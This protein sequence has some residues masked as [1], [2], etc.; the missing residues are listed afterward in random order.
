MIMSASR[1]LLIASKGQ[2]EGHDDY[3]SEEERY[4]WD[5]RR[6]LEKVEAS[7]SALRTLSEITRPYTTGLRR[8]EKEEKYLRDEELA[9]KSFVS[10]FI[11][12]KENKPNSSAS[13]TQPR[14]ESCDGT[15][16]P[17]TDASRRKSIWS[18]VKHVKTTD[19]QAVLD[20]EKTANWKPLRKSKARQSL[21]QFNV[22]NS[23]NSS[24]VCDDDVSSQCKPLPDL[25]APS[26][27]AED[28]RTP[29]RAVV[30]LNQAPERRSSRSFSFTSET[31]STV[32]PLESDSEA[33]NDSSIVTSDFQDQE[34]PSLTRA[35]SMDSEPVHH[36]PSRSSSM[37]SMGEQTP[38][39]Q[40]RSFLKN[41]K[42]PVRCSPI[43]R[44]AFGEEFAKIRG[45]ISSPDK[46]VNLEECTSPKDPS[47][48][49]KGLVAYVEVRRGEDD[50]TGGFRWKLKQ[51]GATV[52]D[53]LNKK[54]T[55]CVF[56][57]GLLST[58][59]K[60]K[61]MGI[62]IV[63]PHWVMACDET[64]MR[65]QESRYPIEKEEQYL[66]AD[67]LQKCIKRPKIMSPDLGSGRDEKIISRRLQRRSVKINSPL[68]QSAPLPSSIIKTPSPK[69]ISK[70]PSPKKRL[71][72]DP[73]DDYDG[74]L[75]MVEAQVREKA[76]SRR[77]AGGLNDTPV[78]FETRLQQLLG[79]NDDDAQNSVK[80]SSPPLASI[81]QKGK[82]SNTLT[83]KISPKK[84][85]KV[86]PTSESGTTS[87]VMMNWLQRRSPEAGQS[88]QK[89]D[90]SSHSAALAAS[91]AADEILNTML[92]SGS[93]DKHQVNQPQLDSVVP[94]KS[95]T[96]DRKGPF[97][98][99]AKSEIGKDLSKKSTKNLKTVVKGN[100]AG[101]DS[102]RNW[103]SGMKSR[104]ADKLQ[105]NVTT[106]VK[107]SKSPKKDQNQMS[108][109][110]KKRKVISSDKKEILLD[111]TEVNLE[112]TNPLKKHCGEV[113]P[114]KNDSI[115]YQDR[116]SK[117]TSTHCSDNANSLCSP[118]R[119]SGSAVKKDKTR[120]V[121]LTPRR[122]SLRLTPVKD[123]S[124]AGSITILET[125]KENKESSFK[126]AGTFT[127]RKQHS[128]KSTPSKQSFNRSL[129]VTP[130]KLEK[131]TPKKSVTPSKFAKS[132]KPGSKQDF[133]FKS[134]VFSAVF[135]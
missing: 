53:T 35:N 61:Q 107:S 66:L 132:V 58:Y 24:T 103:L 67:P 133:T 8:A 95:E 20:M 18:P 105:E 119:G 32:C 6:M 62:H 122:R 60:A 128:C 2:K 104:V 70:V 113:T 16:K 73:E 54:V 90:L 42:S 135:G 29:L 106:S 85:K 129:T 10:N 79:R 45:S 44:Q 57:E 127:P 71:T 34:L 114:K 125:V 43:L 77:K 101:S 12:S 50:R 76:K 11:K 126:N 111:D 80:K 123:T 108:T 131:S 26:K 86:K 130:S 112:P 99:T 75:A 19:V 21:A 47:K 14:G 88:C 25:D 100:A 31:V 89:R 56:Q 27:A 92:T 1:T 38:I 3:D 110:N 30:G 40:T 124:L 7:A 28:L 69:K 87:S 78:D 41:I 13:E 93:K 98:F 55:H 64:F 81:F 23:H 52:S 59:R 49:L 82:S 109:D 65:A 72:S 116:F 74:F 22:E 46:V 118:S 84:V 51:L 121:D 96:K 48:V 115:S 39:S 83:Q 4:Q 94:T 15:D 97:I 91:A 36:T 37:D 120:T 5:R 17:K 9:V 68:I 63:S 117:K 102:M 134:G 33:N